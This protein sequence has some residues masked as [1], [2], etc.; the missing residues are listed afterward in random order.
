MCDAHRQ[1][2]S[3]KAAVLKDAVAVRVEDMT[4]GHCASTITKAIESSI[5]GAKVT[6][7][8]AARLVSVTGAE[9][10]RIREIIS[11]AGYT[12]TEAPVHA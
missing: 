10:A 4:C 1:A 8:P 12:P 11:L 2:E 5:P 6:A 9:L 3:Q 7:N